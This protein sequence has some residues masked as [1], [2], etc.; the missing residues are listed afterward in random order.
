M[1]RIRL[2]FR[3]VDVVDGLRAGALLLLILMAITFFAGCVTE[4]IDSEG[5]VIRKRKVNHQPQGQGQADASY[6]RSG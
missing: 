1:N 6:D 3:R 4:N 5:N 2:G